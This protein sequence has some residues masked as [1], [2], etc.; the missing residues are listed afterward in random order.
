M[1]T[2][3]PTTKQVCVGVKRDGTPCRAHAASGSQYCYLH[4]PAR[5]AAA[6]AARSRGGKARN[7]PAPAP[8]IDLSTPELQRR[9]VEETIDRVRRGDEPLNVGRFV[10]YAVSVVRA[11]ADD[12]LVKR[13]EA[14]EQA[15]A[16]RR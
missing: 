11:V 7:K 9:A 12:D 10:V 2:P 8:P 1:A 6:R 16:E 14:L 13:L 15:Y 5:Q 3:P 4:D